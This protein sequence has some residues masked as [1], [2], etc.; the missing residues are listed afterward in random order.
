MLIESI[1]AIAWLYDYKPKIRKQKFIKSR[2]SIYNVT[3]DFLWKLLEEKILRGLID[4]IERSDMIQRL[5]RVSK[6][7]TRNL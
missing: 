7:E 5:C 4:E 1:I 3:V 2:C 6:A